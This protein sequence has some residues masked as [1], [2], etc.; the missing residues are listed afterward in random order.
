MKGG[1]MRKIMLLLAFAAVLAFSAAPAQADTVTLGF[2]NITNN[3]AADA[4]T[5]EAQLFVDVIKYD[6]YGDGTIIGPDQVAFKFRNTGPNASYISD[7]Y[8][9]DGA[10]LGIAQVVNGTGVDFKSPAN[11]ENLPG[12]ND[13]D[14]KFKTTSGFSAQNDSGAANGVNP[15]EFVDIIFD[16]KDSKTYADVIA[17][18]ALPI[19]RTIAPEPDNWLRIGIHVQGFPPPPGSTVGGSESFVNNPVPLPGAVLLL[20]AGLVRL[21]AYARRRED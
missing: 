14:P 2:Y 4:A 12:G 20:G 18:L 8:F 19:P 10:L 3:K 21:V 15:G 7:I 5:G 1:N 6:Q 16:L 17:A 13:I 11:N 9:D